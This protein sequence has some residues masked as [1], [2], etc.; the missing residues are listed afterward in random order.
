LRHSK[1]LKALDLRLE[2]RKADSDLRA[3]VQGLPALL[4]LAKNSHDRVAAATGMLKSGA[5]QQW[6][7]A[8]EEDCAAVRALE[9]ELPDADA[10]YA[11]ATPHELESKLVAVHT[12]A[13]RAAR[14]REKYRE[15]LAADNTERDHLREDLRVRSQANFEGKQ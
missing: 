2:L 11:S 6:T 4:E 8:W 12:I 3:D 13:S 10:T 7:S 5:S 9:G 15:R 14:L 1:Q